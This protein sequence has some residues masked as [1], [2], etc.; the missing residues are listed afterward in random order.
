MRAIRESDGTD[1]RLDPRLP[2][3][4]LTRRRGV[5]DPVRALD[6]GA[7]D[8]VQ[9]PFHYEELRARITALLRRTHDRHATPMRVGEILIDPSRRKVTVGGREVHLAK[10]E[11]TLL[12]VL[13]SDPTR[14]FGK[15]EL[16]RDVWGLRGPSG[17][18]RTLD[19]HASRLRRKLDPEHRRYVVNCWGIGYQLVD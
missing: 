4:V 10:K 15:D 12:R 18:T 11:F 8:Y 6:L 17:K 9:K 13:A 5:A 1:A 3:I 16:V 2:I 7:D 14:V 19:G